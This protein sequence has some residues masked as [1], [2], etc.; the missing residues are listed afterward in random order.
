MHVSGLVSVGQ[1]VTNKKGSH[2]GAFSM[3]S[4][5]GL[6]GYNELAAEGFAT[7]GGEFHAVSA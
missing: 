4:N 1:Q 2:S 6:F 5:K 3:N 7:G